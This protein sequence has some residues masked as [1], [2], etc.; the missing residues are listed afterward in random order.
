MPIIGFKILLAGGVSFVGDSQDVKKIDINRSTE[1]VVF[2]WNGLVRL[3]S[4]RL[5]VFYH[6]VYMRS[7][8]YNICKG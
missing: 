1:K 2:I 7:H 3:L 8:L 4:C 5:V 6:F